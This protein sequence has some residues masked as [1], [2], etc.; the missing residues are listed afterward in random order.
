MVEYGLTGLPINSKSGR[1]FDADYFLKDY[2]VTNIDF[3]DNK[4]IFTINGKQ[5]SYDVPAQQIG[6]LQK[7]HNEANEK[8]KDVVKKFLK[9]VFTMRK[10][11]KSLVVVALVCAMAF[12]LASCKK[13]KKPNEQGGGNNQ[14]TVQRDV[15][16]SKAN[17]SKM[18]KESSNS[19]ASFFHRVSLLIRDGT[20]HRIRGIP[21]GKPPLSRHLRFLR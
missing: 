14:A 5:V 15:E 18:V 12:G 2:P 20:E 13:D 11:L 8:F 4:L 3:E 9:E 6:E 16:V 10:I 1:N 17:L 7:I 19:L 21:C